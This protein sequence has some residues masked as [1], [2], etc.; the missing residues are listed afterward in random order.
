[1][2]NNKIIV[3]IL[4]ATLLNSTELVEPSLSFQA[5]KGLVKGKVIRGFENAFPDVVITF[6]SGGKKTKVVSD[7]S[8]NYEI[9]LPEGTYRITAEV[10]DYYPFRRSAFRVRAAAVTII[11]LRLT[12]DIPD[13]GH[14]GGTE[15]HYE[16]LMPPNSSERELDL[17]VKYSSRKEDANFI[18]YV[19]AKLYY[20][21]L[22]VSAI[23]IQLDKKDFK[24]KATGK[25]IVDDGQQSVDVRQADVH[26]A[27]STPIV[28]LTYG[29]VD[30]ISGKGSLDDQVSFEFRIEKDRPGYFK[31]E[32]K[33][34]GLSFTGEAISFSVINEA[35][36]KVEFDGDVNIK[37]LERFFFYFQVTAQ[38]N[39][40]TGADYISI[41]LPFDRLNRSGKLS[42]GD[43]EVHRKY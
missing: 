28:D 32:D 12:D 25:V 30:F 24:F 14:G 8:G 19:N 35:L 15:I 43:I 3:S 26:F 5:P 42:K 40:D 41:K 9:E 27:G 29:A 11:N 17:L 13:T 16:N 36:N 4:I 31:Y 39:L 22:A 20:D 37:G 33:K 21:A 18:E 7:R 2:R 6:E 23:N 34:N 1:M 10:Q 38:D